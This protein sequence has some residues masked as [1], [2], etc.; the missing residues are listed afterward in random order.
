MLAASSV[1]MYWLFQNGGNTAVP[2]PHEY[3]SIAEWIVGAILA[4]ALF[5]LL[6]VVGLFLWVMRIHPDAVKKF[7]IVLSTLN[8]IWCYV[9]IHVWVQRQKG[10]KLIAPLTLVTFLFAGILTTLEILINGTAIL[11]SSVTYGPLLSASTRLLFELD[12]WRGWLH[13]QILRPQVLLSLLVI[14]VV[15]IVHHIREHRH[16][17]RE[18]TTLEIL[19]ALFPSL[20]QLTAILSLSIDANEQE[21]ARKVFIKKLSVVLS[22]ILQMRGTKTFNV[23]VMELANERQELCVYFDSSNGAEFDVGFTLKSGE[24]AAGKA[25]DSQQTV[26]LP[27]VAY[28]HGL[29]VLP[30]TYD[31]LT[32]VYVQGKDGFRSIL[33]VPI[34]IPD[35]SK[36]VTASKSV[37][38]LNL[39]SVRKSA[40][41]EF[42]L[43]IGQI[44]ATILSLMYAANSDDT[45][46]A[47]MGGV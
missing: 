14:E 6:L 12:S 29:R 23:C 10:R 38:V 36:G 3:L 19:G 46:R 5:L 31:V 28:G 33:S 22:T 15:I 30:T 25:F 42:D 27:N 18:E 32:S 8:F 9:L 45:Q 41:S 47:T 4:A 1:F 20:N 24:G 11:V 44:G 40:F 17:R 13:G 39:A 43:V 21:K 16:R 35:R 7:Q 2:H 34:L 26:Y 37:G